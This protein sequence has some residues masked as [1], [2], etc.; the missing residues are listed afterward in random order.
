DAYAYYSYARDLFSALT[1]LQPPPSFWWPLGYPLLLN[2]G[3]LFGGVNV[4]SAQAITVLCGALVAPLAYAIAH[5]IA[6]E[7][8]KIYAGW[9]AGLLCAVVGQLVQS[10]VVIM[11]DAPGL[12]W[13]SLASWLLLRY[14]RT[15]GTGTLVVASL[16]AGLAVW[17]RWENLIFAAPWF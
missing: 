1:H 5:E 8:S 16:A 17:T 10:S 12:M 4:A 14:R 9:I 7:E 3:F 15:R 13:A 6:P 11:A 2:L